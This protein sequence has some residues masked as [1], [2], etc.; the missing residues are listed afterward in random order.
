[1]LS[2]CVY[3]DLC[4]KIQPHIF[5]QEI[6][7]SPMILQEQGGLKW[8]VSVRT[9]DLLILTGKDQIDLKKN[10]L[11]MQRIPNQ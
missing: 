4:E 9:A 5:G 3:Y 1:M 10:H 7:P 6:K 2:I 11:V 8:E